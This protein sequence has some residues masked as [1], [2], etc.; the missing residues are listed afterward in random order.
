MCSDLI[1]ILYRFLWAIAFKLH[2]HSNML[3]TM[4]CYVLL[5]SKIF[6]EVEWVVNEILFVR[7]IISSDIDLLKL[8]NFNVPL[9]YFRMFPV[10]SLEFSRF[11]D[12]KWSSTNIILSNVNKAQSNMDI[13]SHSVKCIRRKDRSVVIHLNFIF[14][15][16]L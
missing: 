10:F 14:F 4:S 8:L 15:L 7:R 5:V 16:P 11:I 12:L 3:T 13:F 6:R 9:L 2:V 1:E